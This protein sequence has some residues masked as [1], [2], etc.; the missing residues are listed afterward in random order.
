MC[1]LVIGILDVNEILEL[2]SANYSSC[3]SSRLVVMLECIFVKK[4]DQNGILML[5][6]WLS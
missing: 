6:E 3:S 5:F 1:V 4:N 2:K